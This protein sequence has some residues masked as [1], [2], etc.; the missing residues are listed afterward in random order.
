MGRAKEKE[1]ETP[2]VEETEGQSSPL[3]P[4]EIEAGT[5]PKRA[6]PR[7]PGADYDDD[8]RG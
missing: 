4:D 7:N 6:M 5:I 3:N 1:E 2:E 8:A